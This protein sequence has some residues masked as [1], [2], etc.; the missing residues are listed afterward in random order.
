MQSAWAHDQDYALS[1]SDPQAYATSPPK[2]SYFDDGEAMLP[3]ELA[4]NGDLRHFLYF[5]GFCDGWYDETWY[6]SL[7]RKH[8]EQGVDE[9]LLES[10]S[11]NTLFERAPTTRP[12][13]MSSNMGTESGQ[14]AYVIT[15]LTEYRYVLGNEYGVH[16]MTPPLMATNPNEEDHYIQALM[17][18]KAPITSGYAHVRDYMSPVCDDDYECDEEEW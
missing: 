3:C 6:G 11:L 5:E 13:F 1:I 4:L 17:I 18:T 8:S 2:H 16:I 15:V 12:V 10:I 7:A 14:T 9:E